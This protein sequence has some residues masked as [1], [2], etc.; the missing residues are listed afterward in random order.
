METTHA[1]DIP[2]GA[3]M[4]AATKGIHFTITDY[5]LAE[6]RCRDDLWQEPYWEDGVGVIRVM[7]STSPTGLQIDVKPFATVSPHA[8]ARRYQRCW[9]YSERDRACIIRDIA[10]LGLVLP[11]TTDF[12]TLHGIWR[13]SMQPM[14]DGEGDRMRSIRAYAARTW[15]DL[16][17]LETV[18][19]LRQPLRPLDAVSRAGGPSPAVATRKPVAMAREV[20]SVNVVET[21]V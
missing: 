12:G 17:M 7:V 13:G 5:R 10:A 15:L 18:P 16:D 20:V 19:A 8:L 11:G 4:H 9:P 14:I 1:D 3:R 2:Y 21:L 6:L